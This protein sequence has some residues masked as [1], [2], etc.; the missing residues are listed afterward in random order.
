MITRRGPLRLLLLL[1]AAA[2]AAVVLSGCGTR[3]FAPHRGSA[4]AASSPGQ[5]AAADAARII[6]SFP[7][8][9][10]AVRTGPIAS[11]TQPGERPATPDLAT[12]TQWWR[13]PGRPPSV[14]AW[15][16]AHLP[17]GFTPDV[18]GTGNGQWTDVFALPAVPDVLTQR[19]LVVL[20]VP[21]GGQTAIRAD[22][23]VVWLP[24][25]PAAE[26]IPSDARVVT[27][28]PVFGF[29]PD[30]RYER[31]DRAFTVT[32][33]AK[34]ARI[35]AVIDG[36]ARFP[37]GTFSCPADFGGL[38]R[39]TFFARPGG[40]VLARVAAQYGG[41]G[42]VSVRIGSRDMPALSAYPDSGPPLQQ[43]VLAI[44][45]VSWLVQPGTPA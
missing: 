9:P 35:A 34:V 16:R 24:A 33:P 20:A 38:M 43:Q 25:R 8:P 30:P 14:L 36:L 29:Y 37:A 6:A 42:S 26:R 17:S 41:C 31:L 11:L 19:E 39:L 4:P 28:T 10:G 1:C 22:A 32:D 5:R 15:I 2:C 7:R 18:T 12:V 45:G 3:S 27:V 21:D 40:P 23:Q 13:V 44:A